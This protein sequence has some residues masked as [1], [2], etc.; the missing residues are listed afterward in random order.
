MWT[1]GQWPAMKGPWIWTGDGRRATF[2]SGPFDHG[3][4]V[5]AAAVLSRLKRRELSESELQNCPMFRCLPNS[6]AGLTHSHHA[7]FFA[8]PRGMDATPRSIDTPLADWHH[9]DPHHLASTCGLADSIV[10]W[11]HVAE[12]F[13]TCTFDS[14]TYF[15]ILRQAWKSNVSRL[16]LSSLQSRMAALHQVAADEE[17]VPAW[18]HCPRGTGGPPCRRLP[19]LHKRGGGPPT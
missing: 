3:T 10:S 2:G 18:P 1:L 9:L 8:H 6:F 13:L 16:D 7:S 5:C 17:G 11:I 19:D 12:Y 4:A 14:C 15:Q